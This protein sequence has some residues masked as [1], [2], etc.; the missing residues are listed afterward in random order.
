MRIKLGALRSQ[1]AGKRIVMVDDSIVRGTTSKA[2]IN[3]LRSAGATEVRVRRLLAG[4]HSPPVTFGT[5]IPNK[6]KLIA[7]HHTVDEICQ[8]AGA[9]SL[10]FLSLENLYKI[11][12]DAQLRLLQTAASPSTTRWRFPGATTWPPLHLR[13]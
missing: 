7:C 1:V 11:A 8:I 12:P 13:G 6:D 5:D 2:I 3:L 10:E 9:D 4:L